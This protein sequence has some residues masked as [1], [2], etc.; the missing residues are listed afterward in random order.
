VV[1][2]PQA[3]TSPGGGVVSRLDVLAALGQKI[4]TDHQVI[5]EL[6]AYYGGRAPMS[7]LSPEA[8]E[9]LGTRLRALGVNFP[10][11]TVDSLAERLRIVGFRDGEPGDPYDDALMSAWRRSGMEDGSATAHIEALTVGR[12]FVSVWTRPDGSPSVSVE[13]ARQ[14]AVARDPVTREVTHAAK[15]WVSGGRGYAVLY[16]PDV[17]TKYISEGNVI[18]WAASSYGWNA[19]ESID[20]PLGVVPVVPLV[21]R[22]RLLDV[23]G[24]SEMEPV[25]DLSDALTKLL[26]DLMVTSEMYARPR[27]WVTGLEITEDDDGNPINPFASEA[28]KIW[29]SESPETKFGQFDAARLD[30]Y[31]DAI[32]TLTQQIGALAGLPPHYLGLHG[33]EPA[34]ADAIR[35]A[36]ASLVARALAKQ[37]TFGQAWQEVARLMVAVRDNVKPATVNVEPVWASAETRTPAQA[38]DAAA[39][40]VAAGIIPVSTALE[41][42]GY[43]PT[44]IEKMRGARRADALDAQSIDLSQFGAA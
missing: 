5:A 44:Q 26:T 4:D 43:T 22:G 12:C 40:L 17:I 23:D 39:K 10:R 38:A 37:R 28:Q 30:G 41:D 14:V 33:S 13:S 31:A 19:L 11:L 25:L 24:V 1:V 3:D 9:A 2:E 16:E 27:R 20:N 21:N 7:F 29:Q 35:S 8:R 32:A 42:L 15:R 34:S 36:E 18:D 6:D